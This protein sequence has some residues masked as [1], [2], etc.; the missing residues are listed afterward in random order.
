MDASLLNSKDAASELGISVPTFY[1]WLS[2]SRNGTFTL[3]GK[4]VT[5]EFYQGGRCGQ[6]RIRIP[7]REI[8]RLLALMLVQTQ[9]KPLRRAPKPRKNF[10]NITVTPGR[11][12]S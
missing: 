2:Q 7:R 6:G 4:P 12:E 9:P 10:S 8:D 3:R 5:I 1:D 11:P